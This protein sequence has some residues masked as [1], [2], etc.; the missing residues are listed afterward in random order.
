MVCKKLSKR[1]GLLRSIRHCLPLKERIQFY[2]A[3]IKPIFTYG[4]LIWSSTSKDNLRRVFKLKKR[5]ARV[6]LGTR[7]REEITFTLFNKL[8]WLA[9]DEELK[10]NAC[11]LVFKILN[12]LAP[13]YFVNTF[14]R[15]SDISTRRSSRYGNVPLACSKYNRE[16]EGGKSFAVSATKLWNS[17][18]ATIRLS[19][20]IKTFKY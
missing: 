6:I 3:I 1:I 7:I 11:C 18:P 19:S 2:N 15:V 9:F 14:S 12:G 16:T 4:G 10:L 17:I 20:N 5:A 8:N 13:D